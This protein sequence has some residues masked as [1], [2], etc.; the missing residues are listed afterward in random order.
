MQKFHWFREY[1]IRTYKKDRLGSRNIAQKYMKNNVKI[2]E[3]SS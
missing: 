2:C 1:Y 3:K